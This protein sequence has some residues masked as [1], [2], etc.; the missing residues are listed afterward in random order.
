MSLVPSAPTWYHDKNIWTGKF[1]DDATKPI[2]TIRM[3][4]NGAGKAIGGELMSSGRYVHHF[5]ILETFNGYGSD[6]KFGITDGAPIPCVDSKGGITY[7]Y[8][9]HSSTKSNCLVTI[10]DGFNTVVGTDGRKLKEQ[11][12]LGYNTTSKISFPMAKGGEV[13]VHVDADA[14]TLGF[15]I[16]KAGEMPTG[17]VTQVQTGI[18]QTTRLWVGLRHQGD[19]VRLLETK[20]YHPVVPRQVGGAGTRQSHAGSSAGSSSEDNRKRTRE[21]IELIEVDANE[22]RSGNLIMPV[23]RGAKRASVTFHF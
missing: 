19:T 21:V 3:E 23:P 5:K 18:P 22:L 14:K 20:V 1:V 13:L 10:K 8:T 15:E 4:D 12:D 6:I 7:A 11:P 16:V 2:D 9:V 17:N